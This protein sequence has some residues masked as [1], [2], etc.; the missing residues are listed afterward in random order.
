MISQKDYN[1][2]F[3]EMLLK[4]PLNHEYKITEKTYESTK[5]IVATIAHPN[6]DEK[7]IEIST[8]GRE[9]T[10]SILKHHEHHDSLEDDD[11][12]DEFKELSLYIDDIIN[13]KVFFAVGYQGDRI[14][15]GT[16]SYDINDLLDD[17]ADLIEMKTWSGKQD[18]TIKNKG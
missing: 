17:D 15:Y 10:L 2:W 16:A 11:H 5:Y 8:Y 3:K 1:D 4:H 12:E 7:D 18:K 9:L 14:A 13:D 6:D